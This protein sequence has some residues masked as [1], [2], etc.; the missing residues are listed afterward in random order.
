MG[1]INF[2]PFLLIKFLLANISILSALEVG[3]EFFGNDNAK[4]KEIG[5]IYSHYRSLSHSQSVSKHISNLEKY[6]NIYN[7]CFV[8]LINYNGIDL[9]GSQKNPMQKVPW[10]LS[11]YDVVGVV[12]NVTSDIFKYSSRPN[13]SVRN[14]MYLFEKIPT[15][16]EPINWCVRNRL[17]LECEDVNYQDLSAKVRPWQCEA[18]F[19]LFP[20]TASESLFYEN[21]YVDSLTSA[22]TGRLLVPGSMKRL[23]WVHSTN[24]LDTRDGF[25]EDTLLFTRLRH[26]ILISTGQNQVGPWK[27]SLTYSGNNWYDVV[28]T[29]KR[30]LLIAAVIEIDKHNLLARIEYQLAGIS[31]LCRFCDTK[32]SMKQVN[33]PFPE[34]LQ[35]LQN[36]MKILNSDENKLVYKIWPLGEALVEAFYIVGIP[37]PSDKNRRALNKI[38]RNRGVSL[39][40]LRWEMEARLLASVFRN[41]S[42][43]MVPIGCP[44][45]FRLACDDY[46][47]PFI[48]I[49]SSGQEEHT[50]FEFHQKI[51]KFVSCGA[52]QQTGLVFIQLLSVFD[53]ILWAATCVSVITFTLISNLIHLYHFQGRSFTSDLHKF[54]QHLNQYMFPSFLSYL[55]VL[56]EQGEPINKL[57]WNLPILKLPNLC[58]LF[59][60]CVVSSCYKGE[61][62]NKLTLPREDIPFDTFPLLV[63]N[64]F[65]ILTRGALMGGQI[66][67]GLKG[68]PFLGNLFKYMNPYGQGGFKDHSISTIYKSEVY[69]YAHAEIAQRQ[70]FMNSTRFSSKAKHIMNYSKLMDNWWNVYYDVSRECTLFGGQNNSCDPLRFCNNTALILPDTDAETKYYEM[71]KNGYKNVFISKDV[72]LNNKFGVLFTRWVTSGVLRRMEG[73]YESGVMN[74]WDRFILRFLARLRVG[75]F[76]HA[77]KKPKAS[78]LSG[79]IVVVFSVLPVGISLSILAIFYEFRDLWTGCIVKA[80]LRLKHLLGLWNI[81]MKRY[82]VPMPM[83]K[84]I[85]TNEENNHVTN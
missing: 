36:I 69:V 80:K 14:R 54:K 59:A 48:F 60:A 85:S 78:D 15:S 62:I 68:I 83:S 65:E 11:R 55:R 37:L 52:P 6:L 72:L 67:N 75:F 47:M 31:V 64:H 32:T 42:F 84:P 4:F 7:Q 66:T 33:I 3:L 25:T 41:S 57:L 28:A 5:R 16:R 17:D 73:L 12:Y 77:K 39:N 27:R 19:Y 30:E 2:V 18:H 63:D 43:I 13:F 8:H 58:F 70:L 24:L 23:F 9:L 71:K 46:F 29:S 61:N 49:S 56:I 34:N 44:A 50:H 45:D 35:V 79:N 81:E 53:P 76:D 20:P 26:D 10:I 74:W 21:H 1:N 51:L 40:D 38:I 22:D 82:G